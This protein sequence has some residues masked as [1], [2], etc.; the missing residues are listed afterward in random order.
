[1]LCYM[2]TESFIFHVKTHDIYKETAED[3]ETRFGT[4]NY[5]LNRPLTKG[6]NKKVT[7]KM[8]DDLGRKIM[9]EFVGLRAKAYSYL[10]DYASE[11]KKVIGTKKC[12]V[13]GKLKFK[14]SKHCRS[15]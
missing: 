1:M 11:D 15:N 8:K 2:G 9:K 10:I 12:A 5:K 14:D 4:S 7:G 13:K 6:K 3:V